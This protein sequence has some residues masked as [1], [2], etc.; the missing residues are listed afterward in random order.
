M[1]INCLLAFD[2][3]IGFWKG[4]TEYTFFCVL[5]ILMISLS[6]FLSVFVRIETR[7]HSKHNQIFITQ[8]A[9]HNTKV[10]QCAENQI[11]DSLGIFTGVLSV[12]PIK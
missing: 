1:T 3:E 5:S 9:S 6:Y 8:Y 10:G 12:N 7:A 2:T 4:Q 11:L